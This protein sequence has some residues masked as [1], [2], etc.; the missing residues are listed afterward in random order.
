MAEKKIKKCNP[1]N[2]QVALQFT[3]PVF[4]KNFK[5]NIH[6][7]PS[8]KGQKN[9]FEPWH[10]SYSYSKLRGGYNVNRYQVYLPENLL[11]AISYKISGGEEIKDE[12]G[13]R[14]GKPI[15]VSFFTDNKRPSWKLANHTAIIEKD[16]DN[17][18]PL[19][20]TNLKNIKLKYQGLSSKKTFFNKEKKIELSNPL[21]KTVSLPLGLEDLLE[22]KSGAIYGSIT[23]SPD[24]GQS[25]NKFF[26]QSTH[27]QIMAKVGHFN[28]LVWV[29]D[30][31]KENIQIRKFK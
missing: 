15:N 16:I 12:F 5:G 1:I 29:T 25:Y 7:E 27:F 2:G 24:T 13:R 21:N 31:N 30:E 3:S 6:F 26:Y 11:P 20:V 10:E 17:D 8:L 28:T 9:N 18:I 22:G 19:Y 14:L 4:K 23:G